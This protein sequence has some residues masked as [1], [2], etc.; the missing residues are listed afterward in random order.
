MSGVRLV[1]CRKISAEHVTVYIFFFY[2]TTSMLMVCLLI[3]Q[4]FFD[5]EFSC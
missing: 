2:E 4:L 5:E 3:E 1:S